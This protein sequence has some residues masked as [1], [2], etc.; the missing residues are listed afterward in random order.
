V[1]GEPVPQHVRLAGQG[2]IGD[3]P[4]EYG[5]RDGGAMVTSGKLDRGDASADPGW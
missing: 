4:V 3:E 2:Q 5:E 1:D